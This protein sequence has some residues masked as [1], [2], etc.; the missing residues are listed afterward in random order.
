MDQPMHASSALE[1]MLLATV[2]ISLRHD[3]TGQSATLVKRSPANNADDAVEDFRE[4][5]RELAAFDVR[6]ANASRATEAPPPAQAPEIVPILLTASDSKTALDPKARL[7][8]SEKANKSRP[9]TVQ[10]SGRRDERAI[11]PSSS[12]SRLPSPSKKEA[13]AAAAAAAALAEAA[14]AQAAAA[15]AAAAKEDEEE[16][17]GYLRCTLS[18]TYSD[19]EACSLDWCN[20]LPEIMALGHDPSNVV[21]A[22]RNL[23][24]T[25]LGIEAID[26]N[27]ARRLQ[28][29]ERI[30]LSDN[31]LALLE[32][33]PASV[34]E[35]D[36]YNNALSDVR[37]MCPQLVHLGLGLNAF[38]VCPTLPTS[39]L[40]LDLSFNKLVALDALM[41]ALRDLPHL[42]H[43]FLVGNPIALC[44]G[45][46]HALLTQLPM[47]EVVDDIVIRDK[48]REAAKNV[49]FGGERS[50]DLTAAVTVLGLPEPTDAG[51][52]FAVTVE[53]ASGLLHET[54]A[55]VAVNGNCRGYEMARHSLAPSVALRDRLKFQGLVVK[56]SEVRPV[57]DTAA[58][59]TSSS[60]LWL[61][62]IVDVAAFLKPAS[63]ELA[64]GEICVA[65]AIQMNVVSPDVAGAGGDY[66]LHVK[67]TLNERKT[68]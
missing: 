14:A 58:E 13:A 12:G 40:S 11:T 27:F 36:A 35:V 7:S 10:V 57:L 49:D 51:P 22:V 9:V 21:R 59:T 24:L 53:I 15:A 43:V 41:N 2:G 55:E 23:R 66:Q 64:L 8:V 1:L 62:M 3:T 6:L 5:Q 37:L 39:L 38:A 16:E 67:L 18:D 20:E 33:L 4:C 19:L 50:V 46:R 45:Y 56:V 28:H 42:R 68:K 44:R 48:E 31:N 29:L 17:L 47:L 30:D 63:I 34:L 25:K 32:H 52:K 65:K 54:L 61:S 60:I 26:S